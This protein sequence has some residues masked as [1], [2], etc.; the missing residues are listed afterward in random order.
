VRHL[1][2]QHQRQ[3]LHPTACLNTLMLKRCAPA[4]SA[5]V[6]PPT[7]K[8]EQLQAMQL[9]L[10]AAAAVCAT[11]LEEPAPEVA[12]VSVQKH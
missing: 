5:A 6:K 12:A 1:V 10:A 4:L 2:A 7:P 11:T 9:V 8:T 3:P